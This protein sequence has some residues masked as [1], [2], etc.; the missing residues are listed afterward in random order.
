[1]KDKGV[2]TPSTAVNFSAPVISSAPASKTSVP[3]V[4]SSQNENASSSLMNYFQSF[5]I[6]DHARKTKIQMS[7]AS[8]KDNYPLPVMDH[9]LQAVT[10]AEMMSMLDGFSS[11]NQV[12]VLE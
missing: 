8:L 5:D 11:Y 1:M 12:E 10:G 7:E 2:S 4:V 9:V 6:I 3:H